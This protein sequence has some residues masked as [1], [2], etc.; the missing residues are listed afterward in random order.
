MNQEE[1]ILKY[2]KEIKIM[3]NFLRWLVENFVFKPIYSGQSVIIDPVYI[4]EYFLLDS[5][6]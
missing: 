4:L 3:K 2:Y 6:A 5:S 1:S